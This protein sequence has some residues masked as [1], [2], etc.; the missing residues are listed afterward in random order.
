M[1]RRIV[2]TPLGS[3]ISGVHKTRYRVV[4]EDEFV[5]DPGSKESEWRQITFLTNIL[6]NPNLL[7]CGD[8]PFQTMKIYHNGSQWICEAEAELTHEQP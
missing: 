6:N 3:N 7:I 2:K 8:R 1:K 5:A 4:V